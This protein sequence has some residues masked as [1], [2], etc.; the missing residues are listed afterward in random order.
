MKKKLINFIFIFILLFQLVSCSG[1]KIIETTT[2][3]PNQNTNSKYIKQDTYNCTVPDSNN[4]TGTKVIYD[5][6]NGFKFYSTSTIN[7]RVLMPSSEPTK[8][9]SKFTGW[10]SDIECKIPFNFKKEIKNETT[11]YAVTSKNAAAKHLVIV[12]SFLFS[13]FL[14]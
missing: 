13:I 2:E 7:N 5:L 4:P 6:N 1:H 11:V 10:Y 3:K 14:L 8:L 12:F 9:A